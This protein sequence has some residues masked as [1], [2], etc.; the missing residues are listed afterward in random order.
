MNRTLGILIP[1]E[2]LEDDIIYDFCKP[3]IEQGIFQTIKLEREKNAPVRKLK[4]VVHFQET[5]DNFENFCAENKLNV[6][7]ASIA[8]S[9]W[10]LF[11]KRGK[12]QKLIDA[13]MTEWSEIIRKI[14]DID[15]KDVYYL[16]VMM[17]HFEWMSKLEKGDKDRFWYETVDSVSGIRKHWDK[18]A[19][20]FW[21]SELRKEVRPTAIGF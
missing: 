18:I 10:S 11:M 6:L 3:Y 15:K 2:A 7:T 12:T 21:K 14:H 20:D 16:S 8:Y 13:D 4:K 17:R 1:Q 19:R 9:F 5:F